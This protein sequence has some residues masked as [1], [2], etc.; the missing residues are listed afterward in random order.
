MTI[1]GGHRHTFNG[2]RDIPLEDGSDVRT[3]RTLLGHRDIST[4]MIYTDVSS[5]GATGVR[6]PY[7]LPD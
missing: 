1:S 3:I 5:L 4:T 7:D 2:A 6:S